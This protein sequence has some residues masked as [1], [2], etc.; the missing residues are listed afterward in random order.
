MRLELAGVF[1]GAF[2]SIFA[3]KSS[4]RVLGGLL[5]NDHNNSPVF[6]SQVLHIV[7]NDARFEERVSRAHSKQY[8]T[9]VR[10][11]ILAC[12]ENEAVSK[13]SKTENHF[14]SKR[15][16]LRG[17]G[18]NQI[19]SEVFFSSATQLTSNISSTA[20]IVPAALKISQSS[21]S[22]LQRLLK[23]NP[24]KNDCLMTVTCRFA[25]KAYRK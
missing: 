18:I 3:P 12:L 14:E 16:L 19:Y 10:H 5:R 9:V 7:L 11:H 13:L 8:Y 23:G 1:L 25:P 21:L 22:L 2:Y 24:W 6:L 15:F 4:V 17:L 20:F